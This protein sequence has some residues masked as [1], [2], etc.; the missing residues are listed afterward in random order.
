MSFE[1]ERDAGI[2]SAALT[3]VNC[4][5]LVQKLQAY[6][7]VHKSPEVDLTLSQMNSVHTLTSYF[8]KIHFIL[9]PFLRKKTSYR[10]P[11]WITHF[12][13]VLSYDLWCE[14]REY[15]PKKHRNTHCKVSPCLRNRCAGDH[16]QEI[17]S[18]E[19]YVWCSTVS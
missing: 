14:I 6:Y 2:L 8:L 10:S 16:D 1:P 3:V 13:D 19:M 4:P 18:R 12:S 5:S 7:H 11:Q 17:I 15:I 9:L